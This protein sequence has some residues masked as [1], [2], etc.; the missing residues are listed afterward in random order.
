VASSFVPFIIDRQLRPEV[1]ARAGPRFER[2]SV[3]ETGFVALV[4][5]VL[6]VFGAQARAQE[7]FPARPV[8]LIVPFPPG[9]GTDLI[10]RLTARLMTQ[11]LGEQVIVDNRGGAGGMIGIEAGVRANADGHTLLLVSASYTAMPSL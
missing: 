6:L 7:R 8:R 2:R 4:C 10:A 5:A 9:G 11:G 3:L 1:I